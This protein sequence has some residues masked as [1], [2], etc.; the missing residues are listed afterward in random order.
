MD[1]SERRI[2]QET[3]LLHAQ[4]QELAARRQ[5]QEAEQRREEAEQQRRSQELLIDVTSHELRQPVSAILNCASLV[6]SN[7][8]KL[9]DDLR[10]CLETSQPYAPEQNTIAT[11]DEDLGALGKLPQASIASLSLSNHAFFKTQFTSAD[12]PRSGYQMSMSLL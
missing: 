6:R 10:L 5:V 3:Q 8:Q 9:R 12:C 7:L 11:I 1:I 2:L 4:E